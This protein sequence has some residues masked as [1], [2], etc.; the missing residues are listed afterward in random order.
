MTG[1]RP[2]FFRAVVAAAFVWLTLVLPDSPADLVA[3]PAM[4]FPLELP[5]ILLTAMALGQGGAGAAIRMLLTALLTLFAVLK[6]A[7]L[8]M[9]EVL[10]RPFNPVAD[11]PLID[12]SVRVIAGSFGVLAGVLAVIAALLLAAGIAAVLWWAL[13]QWSRLGRPGLWPTVAALLAIA[14][15]PL[16]ASGALAGWGLPVTADAT[17]FATARAA[18][19]R[20][21]LDDLRDFRA[22]AASDPM[23]GRVGLLDGIDRDVL[24]LFIESYGRTSFD[25][26][27]YAETHLPTL[28]RAEADLASAGLAIRSGF[29]T[30]PTQGGQSWLAHSTFANGLWV[31]D[32]S[33]HLAALAS[34]RQGLFHHA[35][36]AG[37]RTAAVMPAIT[38][39]WPE[40]QRMGFDRVLASGDLG[41]R[42][43]PFHWVTMPDQFT[44]A[45]VQRLLR[46]GSDPRRLF[47]QVALITSHAPW[48]PVPSLLDWDQLG[49]GRVFNAM[50]EAGDP[51]RVVWRDRDRVRLQYRKAVDYVLQA[52]AA[53]AL[54][55]ADDPPLMI[56]L[57]DHQAAASIALDDRREVPIH[58]IGPDPLVARSAAWGLVPGL[59]PPDD[60]PPIPMQAMRDMI[61]L[62]FPGA[63]GPPA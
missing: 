22:M 7:D 11:L 15:L 61:L 35:G 40:A 29:L 38:R 37:F 13:R 28:R 33:R 51:P 8:A 16:H 36:Q 59:V 3:L 30:S 4:A 54:L 46:D 62:G 34:G 19:A 42:G 9:K 43:K 14:V 27:F 24:V 52:V 56:V 57:G 58:I 23:V 2:G 5:A 20:R 31:N 49:D 41:Y 60:M 17:R 32:Q 50:A 63:D 26:P 18:L 6:V 48:V 53:Y 39:P 44:L 25:T 12:A 1:A 10:G 21:T 45:A 55:T 47:A